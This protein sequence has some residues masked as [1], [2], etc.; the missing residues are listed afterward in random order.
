MFG[1]PFDNLSRHTARWVKEWNANS[2]ERRRLSYPT[3][4]RVLRLAGEHPVASIVFVWLATTS[5]SVVLGWAAPSHLGLSLFPAAW[6]EPELLAYFG[7]LWTIQATIA[8][9]VYPIVIAFVAVLLQRRATAKLSLRLYAIDAAVAPAGGS[10]IALLTWMGLQYVSIPFAP[11]A[12]L[13]VAMIGNSAWFVLNSMLTGWF[14]YRTVRFLDDKARLEVFKRFAVQIALV[15]EVRQYLLG[16]IFAT[17][18]SQALIPGG[19]YSS[20]DAGP[21]VV[22]FPI[23]EGTPQVAVDLKN[24]QQITDNRLCLLRWGVALWLRQANQAAETAAIGEPQPQDPLLVIPIAPGRVVDGRVVLCRVQAGPALGRVAAFFIRHSVVFGPPPTPHV[25]Y[26]TAEILE[27]LA[28]DAVELAERKRFEAAREAVVGLVDLHATLIRS[29]AFVEKSGEHDNAALLQDPYGFGSQRLCDD[30]LKVYRPLAEMAVRNLTVDLTPF[31]GHCYLARRLVGTVRG[32]HPDILTHMFHISTHLMYRLGI[33][34]SEKIEERGLI[35]HD[36]SHGVMLPPPLLGTYER[37]LHSFVGGWEELALLEPEEP[38]L[39]ADEAWAAHCRQARFAAAQAEQT[40]HMLLSAV[41][42]GDKAATWWLADSF[43]KWWNKLEYRFEGFDPYE[44]GNGLLTFACIRKEWSEVR[45]TLDAIPQGAQES[46]ITSE[47]AAMVLWRYWTD[48]RL[49]VICILLDWTPAD[50]PAD[51]FALELA[52][53]LLRGR[54]LK[55]GGSIVADEFTNSSHVLFRLIRLQLGGEEYTQMLDRVVERGQDLRKPDMVSGRVYSSVGADDVDSLCLAQTQILTAITA[56]PIVLSRDLNSLARTWSQDL[57]QLQRLKQ[58][59]Q[60]LAACTEGDAFLGRI[61]IT[62]AI[63][64]TIGLPDNVQDARGWVHA[65]LEDV[66]RLGAGILDDTL[67]QAAVSQDRLDE[68]GKAVS[69]YVLA[70]GAK[71]FPFTI[72]SKLE[73]VLAAGESK[74]LVF[75]GLDKAS[76]T[77]P[78]LSAESS[79][80]RDMCCRYVA[81]TVGALLVADHLK[82]IGEAPLRS[83]SECAFFEDMASKAEALRAQG[84]SPLLLVPPNAPAWLQTWRQVAQ[85]TDAKDAVSVSRRKP[86]DAASVI[87]YFKEVPAHRVYWDHRDCY[88]VCKEAFEVLIYEART[89]GSCV[90]VS[91]EPM[92]NQKL[93]VKFEWK[94]GLGTSQ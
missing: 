59:A 50:A 26:S 72:R 80:T 13:S 79:S 7:T 12:W 42:R 6:K 36:A 81:E 39:K 48:L 47:V 53:A 8:A 2:A 60:Q 86:T 83:D 52:I 35:E 82:A 14:L 77:N 71:V 32:Q 19:A 56:A 21:K 89:D 55:H 5:L 66:A 67:N 16:H 62:A 78:P 54:N 85:G 46:A 34:W 4:E 28:V 92:E 84:L 31:R 75:S 11:T 91:Y 43:L 10:A 57:P 30:W 64:G 18:Q 58:L 94:F 73:P 65:T 33:W 41:F 88:V 90:S 45:E 38:P 40:V 44:T 23:L 69:D 17:A 9:L 3:S 20:E 24:E 76:Y 15:R 1:F 74:L 68:L 29:G 51:A 22:L 61:P 37:A 27:E 49:I 70:T 25:S 87:G 63:R 93:S